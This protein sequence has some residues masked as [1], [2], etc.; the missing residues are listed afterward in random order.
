M[1][2]S[3][4]STVLLAVTVLGERAAASLRVANIRE[5]ALFAAATAA[6]LAAL[7]LALAAAG[8][9]WAILVALGAV[10][11]TGLLLRESA[12]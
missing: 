8:T 9:D 2:R 12:R 1:I 4:A 10:V 3:A 11:A 5:V 6:I 7:L